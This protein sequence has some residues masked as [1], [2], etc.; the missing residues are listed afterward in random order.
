MSSITLSLFFALPAPLKIAAIVI[1]GLFFTGMRVE[2]NAAEK[3]E[4]RAA[5]AV[6]DQAKVR[7][8]PVIPGQPVQPVPAQKA[9][10]ALAPLELTVNSDGSYQLA[11][12]Q[13]TEAQLA[14]ELK[15]AATAT[16][17]RRLVI[18]A[19]ALTPHQMVAS[20]VKL[21]KAAGLNHVSF[22]SK[23]ETP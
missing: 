13:L 8:V 6:R 12:K 23:P 3:V 22:T 10:E 14:K 4:V 2:Q 11:G 20:A 9:A 18:K 21:G 19:D 15:A 16:P 1:G 5:E 17:G 7:P